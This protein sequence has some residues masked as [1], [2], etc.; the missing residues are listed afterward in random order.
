M[1][2]LE[3]QLREMYGRVAYTHKA[4]EK[5]A[6]G[7]VFRYGVIKKIE[8]ALS[9]LAT[10]SLVLAVFGD[11]RCGTIIGAVLTTILL[12]LTLYFKEANLGEQAQKHT[13]VA[14][15]L[16]G[17][18]EALL[19]LLVDINDGRKVDDVRQ[20]RDQLNVTLEEIYKGAPRTNS[21]AYQAAQKALKE[22][23]ELFFSDEELDK[24]LPKQLRVRKS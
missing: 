15:K 11:S 13:V 24:L 9:A 16:W 22:A 3:G 7:Y 5:M 8:I 19:S 2:T 6:D 18:R 14:S 4:H 20:V 23:E 17:I 10:T 12:G 1:K 21:V